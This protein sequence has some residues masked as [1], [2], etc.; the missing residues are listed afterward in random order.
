[1]RRKAREAALKALFQV[2]VGGADA[3][4]AL[5]RAVQEERLGEGAARFARSL[6]DGVLGELDVL[7]GELT[8]YAHDWSPRRMGA[9]DRNILRLACYEIRQGAD[10]P[11]SVAIN[12]AVELAKK[13]STEAAAK[14]V[15]GILGQMIKPAPPGQ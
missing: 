8:R 10:V 6:V 2:D 15:N 1:M 4:E 14:F 12:E 11:P 3:G 5:A 9:V 13:F 7:D